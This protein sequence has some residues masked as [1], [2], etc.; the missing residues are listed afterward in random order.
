[1]YCNIVSLMYIRN[2]KGPSAEPL[3][4]PYLISACCDLEFRIWTNCD[5]SFR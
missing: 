1:M 3:G 4:T 2:M 5:R